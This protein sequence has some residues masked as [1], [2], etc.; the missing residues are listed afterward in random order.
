MLFL[1]LWIQVDAG[2]G[3]HPSLPRT[4]AH[5][6]KRHVVPHPA[7]H[8]NFSAGYD[9]PSSSFYHNPAHTA[10]VSPGG[11]DVATGL[12]ISDE[13]SYPMPRNESEAHLWIRQL[14]PSSDHSSVLANR[15]HYRVWAGHFDDV[16][17]SHLHHAVNPGG[18][19]NLTPDHEPFILR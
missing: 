7:R 5:Q 18:V 3:L 17:R 2:P 14:N 10:H 6:A 12:P 15:H 9:H 8:S 16:D 4:S 1:T 19:P 13:S 11:I